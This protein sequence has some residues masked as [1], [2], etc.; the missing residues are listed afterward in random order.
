MSTLAKTLSAQRQLVKISRSLDSEPTILFR[1]LADEVARLGASIGVE[2]RPYDDEKLPIFS[3]LPMSQQTTIV[4]DLQNYVNICQQ[5][6]AEGSAL[7][8]S[9]RILWNALKVFK[10]RPTSDLFEYLQQGN[11]IEIH[12]REFVQIF[13][14][15]NFYRVCSYSLEELYCIPW[16]RLYTRSIEVQQY[17]VGIAVEMFETNRRT[18]LQMNVDAHTIYE[19]SSIKKLQVEAKMKYLAPLFAEGTKNV[20]AHVLI[21]DTRVLDRTDAKYTEIM[22]LSGP[23]LIDEP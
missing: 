6:V 3:A 12:N 9:A 5:T 20:I 16:T 10:V 22:P 2:I 19:I 8:D 11:T 21:E 4:M 23:P 14:N 13:R 7:T 1:R 17:L 15:F 18:I